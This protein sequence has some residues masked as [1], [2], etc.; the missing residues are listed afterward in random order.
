GYARAK[1]A[2]LVPPSARP[3]E[4]RAMTAI[5]KIVAAHVSPVGSVRAGDAVFVRTDVRFSH[6]YVTPMADAL[7]RSGFGADAPIA[8]PGSVYRFTDPLTLR[9]GML[10]VE[11]ASSSPAGARQGE[12]AAERRERARHLADTQEQFA[13]R[14]RLQLYGEVR[15]EGRTVGSE[16]ICHN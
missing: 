16:G 3:A 1:L 4:E 15:R 14:H 7:F 13:R 2:G 9:N 8:D 5:E 10:A 12:G 11:P 6:E